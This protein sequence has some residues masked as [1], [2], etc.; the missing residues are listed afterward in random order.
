MV[1]LVCARINKKSFFVFLCSCFTGD[2]SGGSEFRK[3]T[4]WYMETHLNV[5]VYSNFLCFVASFYEACEM[6]NVWLSLL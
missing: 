1:S 6:R 5:L 3:F 2:L 4:R